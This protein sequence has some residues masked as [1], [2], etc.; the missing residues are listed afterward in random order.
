MGSDK[1]HSSWEW[2]REGGVGRPGGTPIHTQLEL[3]LSSPEKGEP[4]YE[5]I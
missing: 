4:A 1:I 5:A 3:Y 2:T